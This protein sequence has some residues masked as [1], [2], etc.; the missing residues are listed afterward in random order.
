M[1]TKGIFNDIGISVSI[2]QMR[3][4]Y[5]FGLLVQSKTMYQIFGIFI[6]KMDNDSINDVETFFS[7]SNDQTLLELYLIIM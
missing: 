3:F 6:G 5:N 1:T 7:E 4:N 2:S